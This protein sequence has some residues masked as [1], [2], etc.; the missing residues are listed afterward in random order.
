MGEDVSFTLASSMLMLYQVLPSVSLR[1][2]YF[3][4]IGNENCGVRATGAVTGVEM[5]VH[6]K[7]PFQ[8]G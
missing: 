3:Q 5:H 6:F 8:V 1:L 7:P 4:D 2:G